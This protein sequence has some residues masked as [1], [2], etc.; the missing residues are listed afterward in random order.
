MSMVASYAV[1]CRKYNLPCC[2]VC[3]SL[4]Q[5][6]VFFWDIVSE[7][8]FSLNKTDYDTFLKV[9]NLECRV[10]SKPKS[11]IVGEFLS[12]RFS[13]KVHFRICRKQSNA[14]ILRKRG[15]YLSLDQ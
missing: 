14:V 13:A 7:H 3:G 5:S 2:T 10:P 11:G 15:G 1:P 12:S 8:N 4:F 6:I 9:I